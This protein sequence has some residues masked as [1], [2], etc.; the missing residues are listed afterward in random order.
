MT[1]KR[2]FDNFVASQPL[3]AHNVYGSEFSIELDLQEVQKNGFS[4][5]LGSYVNEKKAV[6]DGNVAYIVPEYDQYHM[7]IQN[8]KK[9][10]LLQYIG[11]KNFITLINQAEVVIEQ[12]L[13][14]NQKQYYFKINQD[15]VRKYQCMMIAALLIDSGLAKIGEKDEELYIVY[16]FQQQL[17]KSSKIQS[18]L[19]RFRTLLGESNNLAALLEL[20]ERG[21]IREDKLFISKREAESIEMNIEMMSLVDVGVA[22]YIEGDSANGGF[23]LD[24]N[25][26]SWLLDHISRTSDR[27]SFGDMYT[28]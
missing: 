23:E 9:Q 1:K 27:I 7:K 4:V 28:G 12:S 18:D 20:V 5:I 6:I 21:E 14:K 2:K 19:S 16:N 26:A 13:G 15:E 22:R 10:K 17:E 11:E 25:F 3:V 8:Y 24:V